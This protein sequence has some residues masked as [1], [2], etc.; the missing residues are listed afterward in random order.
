MS[1]SEDLRA[2]HAPEPVMA[3]R[4]GAWWD[5]VRI[6]MGPAPIET[7]YGWFG[8]YHG[9]KQMVNCFIYRMGMVM[10]DLE[11]P[12][13]VTHRSD[14]WVLGPSADYEVVGDVSNVIF[15]CGALLDEQTDELRVYYGAAD[16]CVAMA[17]GKFSRMV[18]RLLECPQP[19][20]LESIHL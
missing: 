19:P 4:P 15:P 16:T 5:S 13:R 11:N 20:V 3:A 2:W 1:R 6:G 14:N 17:S 9:V 10:L 12:A 7:P 18:E 8:L